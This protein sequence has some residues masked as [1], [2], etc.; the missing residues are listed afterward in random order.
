[1]G[2]CRDV[3][4]A[5]ATEGG[6]TQDREVV[7]LG[8]GDVAARAVRGAELLHRRIECD[9]GR[10]GEGRM[11]TRPC[12]LQLAET[13][14]AAG[15]RSEGN[16]PGAVA[17]VATGEGGA[18]QPRSDEDVASTRCNADRPAGAGVDVL[19]DCYR[20]PCLQGDIAAGSGYPID[21]ADRPYRH[22]VRIGVLEG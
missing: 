11:A 8:D 22:R 19:C 4:R 6:H 9:S 7:G 18:Q 5:V 13:R 2:R 10:S 12:R 20:S 21:A 3:D 1:A 17:D 16:C 14:E 15:T